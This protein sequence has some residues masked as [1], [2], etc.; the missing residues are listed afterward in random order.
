MRLYSIYGTNKKTLQKRVWEKVKDRYF[1]WVCP[2][3]KGKFLILE[4]RTSR[5]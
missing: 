2:V 5:K 1:D 3:I 4:L